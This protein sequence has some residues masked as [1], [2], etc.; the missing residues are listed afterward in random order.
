MKQRSMAAVL[1]AATVL[2]M[3]GTPAMAQDMTK[4]MS[5]TENAQMDQA[6]VEM[7]E[8]EGYVVDIISKLDE[9][10][11]SFENWEYNLTYL[12]E[13]YDEFSEKAGI[14]R[15]YIDLYIETYEDQKEAQNLPESKETT[16]KQILTSGSYNA[17]TAVSYATKYY[18]S[19]NPSY[20]NWSSSGSDSTNFISQCLYV[21]G[22]KMIGTPGTQEAANKTGNWFSSGTSC[23]TKKVS[24]SWRGANTFKLHWMNRATEYRRFT[25]VG[26]ASYK[27]GSKGDVVSLLNSNGA[28][29]RTL[30]IVGYDAASKD[31]L[32]ATHTPNV[33]S[34][35]LKSYNPKDGF[36]IYSM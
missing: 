6:Y 26:A 36:I 2:S 7:L 19:Y 35:S 24:A 17:S 8:R 28:A 15:S 32:V 5:L 33:K 1:T 13:H 18:N 31:F 11:T 27:Y 14:N 4:S 20:P 23:N 25:S 21:G 10:K 3:T 22:K 12:Q 34:K 29:Y 16:G 30:I 9:R